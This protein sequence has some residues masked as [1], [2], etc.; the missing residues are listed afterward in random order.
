[1]YNKSSLIITAGSSSYG[2]VAYNAKAVYTEEYVSKLS[3]DKNG[4]QIYTDGEDKILIGC[5]GTATAISIPD[6][7]T[8]INQYAFYGN[9]SITRVTIPDSVKIICDWAFGKCAGLTSVTIGSG[10]NRIGWGEGCVNLSSVIYNGT[11]LDWLLIDKA[12]DFYGDNSTVTIYCT[13]GTWP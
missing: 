3:T 12:G 9:R 7:I 2:H 6:G 11:M 4:Y 10:V 5:T 8:E 1:M 13:D